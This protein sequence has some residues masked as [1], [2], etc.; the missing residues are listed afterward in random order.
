MVLYYQQHLPGCLARC[1]AGLFQAPCAIIMCAEA[2]FLAS[3]I[4]HFRSFCCRL[5]TAAVHATSGVLF[6]G[7]EYPVTGAKQTCWTFQLLKSAP[8]NSLVRLQS[9]RQHLI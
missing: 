2:Q 1:V 4:V 8:A 7:Q 6:A 3:G 9:C 5:T